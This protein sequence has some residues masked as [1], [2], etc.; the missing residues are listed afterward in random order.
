[1]SASAI[2][3]FPGDEAELK[4]NTVPGIIFSSTATFAEL[5]HK[6][7][8]ISVNYVLNNLIHLKINNNGQ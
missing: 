7:S 8:G 6:V 2:T 5:Y 1:M 4:K 3:P